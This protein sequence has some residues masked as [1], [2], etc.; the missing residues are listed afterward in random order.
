[1]M[2]AGVRSSRVVKR[3]EEIKKLKTHDQ[4]QRPCDELHQI[5]TVTPLAPIK[6]SRALFTSN[7]CKIATF[8]APSTFVGGFGEKKIESSR[9]G[10]IKNFS[11]A[12][13]VGKQNRKTAQ[14]TQQSG[15]DSSSQ[16]FA[17]PR[18]KIKLRSVEL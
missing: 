15:R 10:E 14:C 1:M 2:H 13:P 18:T 5:R 6:D 17:T 9:T 7:Q 11:K 4:E 8:G 12:Y 16:P 3:I